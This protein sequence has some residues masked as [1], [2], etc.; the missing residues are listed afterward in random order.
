[1]RHP[2]RPLRDGCHERD[3][4]DAALERERFRIPKGGGSTDEER[5]NAVEVGVGHRAHHVGNTRTRRDHGDADLARGARIA[6]RGV[7][8]G[9]LVAR[10]DQA[11]VAVQGGLKDRVEVSTVEGE[12]QLDPGALEHPD[13]HLSA[14]Y[15]RHIP[16]PST[17]RGSILASAR[18]RAGREGEVP[19]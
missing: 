13:Q 19:Q 1:M 4:V 16:L 7:P 11:K 12:G 14:I 3:L 15:L 9:L 18:G 6:L 5:G 8:C 10:V 2:G 17:S